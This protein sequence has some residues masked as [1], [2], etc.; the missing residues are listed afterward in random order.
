[1]RPSLRARGDERGSILILSTVGVV[2]ALISAAL[3]VDLGRL[4]QTKRFDQKVADMAALDASRDLTRACAIAK[5][6]AARNNFDPSGLDCIDPAYNPTKDVVIGRLVAGTFNPDPTGDTV[7]VKVSS[8]FKAAFP[9]VSGPDG[10]SVK[11]AAGVREDAGFSIGSSV[12]RVNAASK[13]PVLNRTLERLL[14]GS[15]GSLTLDAVGYQGLSSGSLTLGQIRSQMGF[16]TINE[17]LAADIKVLDFLDAMA[18][19]LQGD[20]VLAAYINQIKSVTNSSQT[21]S[22]GDIIY[23]DQ[24]VGEKAA[25]GKVNVLQMIVAAAEV[26]NKENFAAG[27]VD[28]PNA[29]DNALVTGVGRVGT[30]LCIKVTEGPRVYHGPVGG[31]ASTSQVEIT[32]DATINVP[33][34]LPLPLGNLLKA[35]GSLPVKITAGGATGTLTDIRCSANPGITVS[36]D[37]QAVTTSVNGTVALKVAATPLVVAAAGVSV[38]GS[39][40]GVAQ[41]DTAMPFLHP[42]EFS[43]PAPSKTT[44]SAPLSVATNLSASGS[45]NI[46][47]TVPPLLTVSLPLSVVNQAVLDA[48]RPLLNEISLRARGQEV[49]SLGAAVAIADVAALA[50]FF[51]ATACGNPGL[52][53]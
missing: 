44:P 25:S 37:T 43:P 13:S 52:V 24:G 32:F 5:E 38:T 50:E 53:R 10:V 33:I 6:S 12:A 29:L 4:A 36:V 7:Q 27:C 42:G 11:A 21:F 28:V 49:A 3:A 45:G 23:V 31:S 16:A 19:V 39:A 40:T 1:V 9:F 48:S 8:P 30:D 26:A 17:L 2:V 41:P 47:I 35:E 46:T 18:V 22:L 51:N 14:G 34:A 20:T 15:S